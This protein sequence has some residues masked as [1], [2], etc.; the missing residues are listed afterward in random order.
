MELILNQSHRNLRSVGEPSQIAVLTSNAC[1][2]Y[3]NIV[4]LLNF[5]QNPWLQTG[6]LG[7]AVIAPYLAIITQSCETLTYET[8]RS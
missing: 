5:A 6:V 4:D 8:G 2:R 1:K 3:L 7:A